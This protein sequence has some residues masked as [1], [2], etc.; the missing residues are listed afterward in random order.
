M[1]NLC[2]LY[3]AQ[4]GESKEPIRCKL[5]IYAR[6][7]EQITEFNYLNIISFTKKNIK[8]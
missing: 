5:Q 4:L 1:Q 3:F 8:L 2:Q 6:M 7:V